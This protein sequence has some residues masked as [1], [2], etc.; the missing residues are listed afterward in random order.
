MFISVCQ[1]TGTG[2]MCVAV[3][4]NTAV[5][6]NLNAGSLGSGRSI[7]GGDRPHK[8]DRKIFLNVSEN[9]SCNRKL[10]LIPFM[11]STYYAY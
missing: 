1:D 10:S 8:R 3:Y 7:G 2:H 9:D 4:L 5:Y 6:V 11:S